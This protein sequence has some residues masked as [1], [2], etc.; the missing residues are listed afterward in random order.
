MLA[1]YAY[2]VGVWV[3]G[4]IVS[5]DHVEYVDPETGLPHEPEHHALLSILWPFV[6][7][8][9]FLGLVGHVDE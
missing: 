5:W 4:A 7:L 1:A 9:Y 6:V 3:A 2:A 8:G